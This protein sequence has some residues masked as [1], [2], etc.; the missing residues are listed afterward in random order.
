M[1]R[2]CYGVKNKTTTKQIYISWIEK[3]ESLDILLLTG[4]YSINLAINDISSDFK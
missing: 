4:I 1:F 2:F 3:S